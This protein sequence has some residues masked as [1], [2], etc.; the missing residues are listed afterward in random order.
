MGYALT[1]QEVYCFFQALFPDSLS[2][3]LFTRL[4]RLTISQEQSFPFDVV[5]LAA[6]K[7]LR[8]ERWLD[9]LDEMGRATTS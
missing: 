4:A 8:D 7:A 3:Q 1:I 6:Q 5:L 9:I 2:L